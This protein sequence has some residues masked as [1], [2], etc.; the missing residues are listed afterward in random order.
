M[1]MEFTLKNTFQIFAMIPSLIL[2][3]FFVLLSLFNGD[4][5]AFVYLLGALIA[6]MI[7]RWTSTLFKLEP[8]IGAN[9]L[10]CDAFKMPFITGQY[11]TPYS[12]SA[13]LGFTLL[14]LLMPMTFNNH[15]NISII[16][17]L[18]TL[19]LANAKAAT[20]YACTTLS[21][22]MGG[23]VV[24]GLV[25]YIYFTML[26]TFGAGQYLF[27]GEVMSDRAACKSKKTTFKCVPRKS[28][29]M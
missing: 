24:G 7:N 12:T 18:I 29:T 15:F 1:Y 6:L 14:Y 26:A 17:T 8:L 4:I 22:A 16:V 5:K 21:G 2:C 28:A 11:I 25:G 23:A 10:Y 20:E 19:I 3:T 13:F 9:S 27:F